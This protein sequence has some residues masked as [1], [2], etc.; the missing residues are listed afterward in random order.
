MKELDDQ[1]LSEQLSE[2]LTLKQ[3]EAHSLDT[4][5]TLWGVSPGEWQTQFSEEDR[6]GPAV[7]TVSRG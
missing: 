3:L 1:G 7:P 6:L 2:E 4:T 5:A